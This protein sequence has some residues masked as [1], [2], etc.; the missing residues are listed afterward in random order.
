MSLANFNVEPED[1]NNKISRLY[2]VKFAKILNY[3]I[4]ITYKFEINSVDKELPRFS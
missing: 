2:T 3:I 4:E 1:F